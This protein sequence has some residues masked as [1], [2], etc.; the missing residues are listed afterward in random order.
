ML[1]HFIVVNSQVNWKNC[2]DG[3]YMNYQKDTLN[4]YRSEAR[5]VGYKHYQTRGWNW[6]R[7]IT[8]RQQRLLV[9]EL[10]RYK[11]SDEDILLDVPCGTGVLGRILK[12]L[13][14]CIIACDISAEMM[15]LACEEY[16]SDR[17][18]SCVLADITTMPFPRSSFNC[19]VTLGFLHRVPIEI[20]R[21][22]LCE[23][24]ALSTR[25][26]IADYSIDTALQRLKHRILLKLSRSHIPAPCPTTLKEFKAEC[27]TAGLKVVRSMKVLPFFSASVIFILEKKKENA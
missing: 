10:A 22:A 27:E 20:K 14:L 24:A 2:F 18:I 7:F 5:A 8:W 25:V 23:I 16:S 12:K 3:Y 4:A 15:A 1:T 13:P 26:V 19:V 11:W 17:F 6:A 21:A 9:R